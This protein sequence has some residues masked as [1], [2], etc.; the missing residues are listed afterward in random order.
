MENCEQE[1][2]VRAI[3]RMIE[4]NADLT[5][6]IQDNDVQI[7]FL[8][9]DLLRRTDDKHEVATYL[10]WQVPEISYKSI[11]QAVGIRP[12]QIRNFVS[13]MSFESCSI[14]GA[15]IEYASRGAAKHLYDFKRHN[16]GYVPVCRQCRDSQVKQD[17]Q[18]WAAKQ[19]EQQEAWSNRIRELATMPYTEYLQTPEWQE[20]RQRMLKRARFH[21]QVCNEKK[22]LHVHHRT[23]ERRGH[24]EYGDLIVLCEDCHKLYHF[25]GGQS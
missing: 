2:E 16:A 6:Q 1:P 14:C 12:G 9:A 5:Q 4:E 7:Q 10:Y 21:C 11:A 8:A 18:A 22:V 25:A 15:D 19:K 13:P 20:T 23:Y 3:R 24:E 17:Q